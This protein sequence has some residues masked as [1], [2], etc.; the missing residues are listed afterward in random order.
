MGLSCNG[1][2]RNIAVGHIFY[3][4]TDLEPRALGG[5]PNLGGPPKPPLPT[6]DATPWALRR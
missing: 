5:L 6:C 3:T 2:G 1:R 4:L